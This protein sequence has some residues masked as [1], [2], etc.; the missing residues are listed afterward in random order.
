MTLRQSAFTLALLPAAAILLT[1]VLCAQSGQTT[2]NPTLK[3]HPK[4]VDPNAPPDRSSAYYHDGLAHLYEELALANGRPD[5]AAQAVE[6][7]KLA[8]NA[9]PSSQFLQDGLADLYFKIGRI[10][11]AVSAAQD[12]VKKNPD[13]VAAHTLLGKVYLRS[14]GD[15]Q[16][17]Q[18]AEML[19]LAIGEYKTLAR[20]KPKDL[21]THLLLGQLYGLNHDTAKAEEE[22]KIAQSLDS[23]SEEAV[24]NMARLYSEQGETQQ[25]IDALLSVPADDR[26][27]RIDFAL[28]ASYDQMR[29]FKLAVAAY[30]AA[31]DDE[32]DNPDTER[33][34]AAALLADNQ[35]AEALPVYQQLAAADPTDVESQLKVSEIQRRQGHYDD[36]LVTLNKAKASN[37]NQ[38]NPELSFNEAVLYD[39]LGKYDQAAAALKAVL[40][41]T[42]KPDGK[43]SEPEKNNRGIFLSRLGIVY[44]EEN[45]TPEAVAAYKEMVSLG[46]DYV[47]AGYNGIVDSYRSAHQWKDA[48]SAAA[49][50]AKALPDDHNIQLL[51]AFQLADT[52]Q[53][54]Q[55]IALAK[56]QLKG[57][58]DKPAPDDRDTLV[59]ISNIDLRIH[60][61]AE[62][63]AYLDKADAL[64]LRPDDHRYIDLQRATIY[65]H[66][67]QYDQAEAEY[68]KAL[69]V[70]PSNSMY[71]TVLNDFGYMLADRGVNLAE[72]LKMIQKA[73][74]L[75]P[76]NGAFLDSLGW[77]Y[78]K[79]GQYGPAEENLHKAID[80]QSTDASIH[81][82]LGEVYEKT[83]RLQ[84]AVGQWERS[85]TEYAHSLP[86]DADPA[87]VA[88][89]K[90]KLDDARIKLAR[91]NTSTNK[92]SD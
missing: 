79:L 90:R 37:A 54:D 81:D 48:A 10:R 56:A 55:A 41:A 33:A 68:R 60:R 20:L 23:N 22:F 84:L 21:E 78:F 83:G 4:P 52:G 18:S 24:L 36:A 73:V 39:S 44:N 43:Y 38:E 6:E 51:Y 16:G 27:A 42:Q 80:R 77:V 58:P 69:A 72:A 91:L 65:D 26:S 67:K 40:T 82:H 11:E 25:A 86:A 34:L 1:P 29:K 49:E 63:Q 47:V 59:T 74:E 3:V 66:D 76:Q 14:L 2:S 70:D 12:Q 50:A 92:K 75:E 13:D 19:A 30:R 17:S 46:G 53:P 64:S 61:S 8:L 7:Y 89:V 35:L 15:M 57:T 31:L 28:G 45:K 32:P 62:A 9:D 85:M 5:Y 87:D 88:K 71:A